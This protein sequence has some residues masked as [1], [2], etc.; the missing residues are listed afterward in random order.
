M[1]QGPKALV[2]WTIVQACELPGRGQAG[3]V[4]LDVNAYIGRCVVGGGRHHV[5]D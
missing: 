1:H 3:K 4:I 2:K 5:Y